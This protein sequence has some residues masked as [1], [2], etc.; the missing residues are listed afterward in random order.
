MVDRTLSERDVEEIVREDMR[1]HPD[2]RQREWLLANID[3]WWA[4]LVGMDAEVESRLARSR[5]KEAEGEAMAPEE[6]DWRRRAEGFQRHLRR[7]MAEVRELREDRVHRLED[8]IR[9]AIEL[10]DVG[11]DLVAADR[12]RAALVG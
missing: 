2:G 3:R 1:G 12:L 8:T 11:D 10:L 6:L 5:R 9:Q 4:C 7:K